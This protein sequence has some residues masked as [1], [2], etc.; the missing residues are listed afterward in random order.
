[1]FSVYMSAGLLTGP[2][3]MYLHSTPQ[4]EY[5]LGVQ[6]PSL[7]IAAEQVVGCADNAS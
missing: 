5:N 1:M 4:E 7:R 6:N 3:R 2:A